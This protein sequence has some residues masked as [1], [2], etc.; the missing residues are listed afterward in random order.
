[1]TFLL[2]VFLIICVLSNTWVDFSRDYPN[3]MDVNFETAMFPSQ[4]LLYN[5][6]PYITLMYMHYKNFTPKRSSTNNV[7]AYAPVQ[8]ASNS[9]SILGTGKPR[10]SETSQPG[11]LDDSAVSGMYEKRSVNKSS[12]E[13]HSAMI[14]DQ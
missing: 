4:F 5:F 1:M 9:N 6:V 12:L 14:S 13:D 8:V 10:N 11:I 7:D 3:D 2:R